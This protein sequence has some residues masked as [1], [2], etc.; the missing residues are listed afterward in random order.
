M[1]Q[2]FDRADAGL[3]PVDQPVVDPDDQVAVAPV[4]ALQHQ[5]SLGER[6]YGASAL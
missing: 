2:S 4:E 3:V 1:L 5:V 6:R